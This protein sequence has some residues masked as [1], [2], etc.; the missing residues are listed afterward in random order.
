MSTLLFCG[1][2]LT[3]T[4]KSKYLK[5]NTTFSIYIPS[6]A[7]N[8]NPYPVLY[9]LHG[10]WGS[11]KD[12]PSK[13]DVLKL[14]EKYKM[15]MVFPDGSQFGWY[16]DSPFDEKSQY[17][18][19]IIKELIPLIDKTFPTIKS[20]Y[21]RGIMGLSMGGH[22]AIT[23]V[24]KYP[25][26]F[27]SASSLSGILKL[28]DHP[29]KWHITQK[30]GDYNKYPQNWAKN[31]AYELAS[32]LKNK[33]IFILFDCGK[34]DTKT[35]AIFDN[36]K[37]HKRL[38]QL[39]IP[40]IWREFPG[41]HSWKYWNTHLPQH[42][43]FHQACFTRIFDSG[44]YFKR[45]FDFVKENSNFTLNR[46]SKKIILLLGSSSM[47][48]YPVQ[49]F[50]KEYFVVN[51]G[52]A[53]DVLGYNEKL[54]IWNRMEL[55]VFDVKPD[56]IFFMNGRNDLGDW[57]RKNQKLPDEKKISIKVTVDKMIKKYAEI[58]KT[59]KKREKKVKI[60]PITCPGTNKKYKFIAIETKYYNEK[61]RELFKKMRIDYIDLF[62][63]VSNDDGTL[64]L[65]YTR[66]GLHL[67][68]KGYEI[69]HKE[70]EKFL[71]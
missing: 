68:Q 71:K 47:E 14:A 7:S 69:L 8:K 57:Y 45:L 32:N 67:N 28:T 59:I 50:S 34:K 52:I 51:R 13:T 15:I 12:W 62:P 6:K 66:D 22:G 53:G 17:E 48:G 36:R 64:K 18:S 20:K 3:I 40:H 4:F 41:T 26:I 25:D 54:G 5:K 1:E 33:N 35:G 31:S 21:A 19:F 61:L 11:Y 43:N 30:L 58:I 70:I 10:A 29:E 63:L 23:L 9:I 39:N 2:F 37:F 49:L 65:K 56:I 38:L 16:V 42:L 24:E 60:I 27:G 44:K 46:P 55:S